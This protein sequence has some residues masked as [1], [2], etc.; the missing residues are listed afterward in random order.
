M[1]EELNREMGVTILVVEHLFDK[2]VEISQRMMILDFGRQIYLGPS[3]GVAE[4]PTVIEVY[5][6]MKR[7]A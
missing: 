1:V 6:G 4:D 3:D 2:L 5:L 7:H